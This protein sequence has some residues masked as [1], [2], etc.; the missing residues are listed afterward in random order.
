MDG[1]P[2][3]VAFGYVPK[4]KPTY[5]D[6]SPRLDPCASEGAAEVE[7]AFMLAIGNWQSFTVEKRYYAVPRSSNKVEAS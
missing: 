5:G 6:V 3:E 1:G 7:G 2:C 4:G